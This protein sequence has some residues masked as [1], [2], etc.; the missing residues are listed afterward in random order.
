MD[1]FGMGF[2][3][4]C[5]TLL[6]VALNLAG[7][8]YAWGSPIIIGLFVGT[9][10]SFIAFLVAENK[11]S[12]PIVPMGLFVAWKYRNVPIITVART[13][14]FFHLY[15]TVRYFFHS[16]HIYAHYHSNT[17]RHSTS[18]VSHSAQQL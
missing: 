8:A 7:D 10:V 9:G 17:A 5:L 6:I 12:N 18:L 2:L 14:L 13:L 3:V 4:S 15:A 16:L 1:L 11:A